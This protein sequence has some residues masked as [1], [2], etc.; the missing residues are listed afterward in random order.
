M[1]GIGGAAARTSAA[2]CG[3]TAHLGDAE[4]LFGSV[5]RR[6]RVA[7]GRLWVHLA[8]VGN[9]PG[10]A[11]WKLQAARGEKGMQ[12]KAGDNV[13][14]TARRGNPTATLVPTALVRAQK[15]RPSPQ[16]L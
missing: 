15:A 1:S 4:G 10:L 9:D 14:V 5:Q 7:L 16:S 11:G 8:V 13:G 12:Q 3:H 2:I 6:L